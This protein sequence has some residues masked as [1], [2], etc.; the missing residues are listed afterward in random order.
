MRIRRPYTQVGHFR[1]AELPIEI[2]S[3]VFSL[4]APG[5]QATLCL[6]SKHFLVLAG[7]ELYQA[8]V[9]GSNRQL[10]KLQGKRPV[11]EPACEVPSLLSLTAGLIY[12]SRM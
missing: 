2:Q 4:C 9:I 1:C 3:N 12:I 10:E 8:I 5:T 11:S 7:R 6:V